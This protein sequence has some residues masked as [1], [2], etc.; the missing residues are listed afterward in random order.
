MLGINVPSNKETAEITVCR[1][2]A[3]VSLLAF[4]KNFSSACNK[5]HLSNEFFLKYFIT[6]PAN[7]AKAFL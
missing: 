3:N 6:W 2:L 4:K 5:N 7:A 1:D